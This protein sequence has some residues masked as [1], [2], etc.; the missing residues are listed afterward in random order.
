MLVMSLSP[1]LGLR[2]PPNDLPTFQRTSRLFCARVQLLPRKTHTF[3]SAEGPPDFSRHPPRM[4]LEGH[5][6]GGATIPLK[7]NA[8]GAWCR[9]TTCEFTCRATFP[10]KQQVLLCVT[11]PSSNNSSKHTGVSSHMRINLP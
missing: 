10:G 11:R 8:F 7:I 1:L 3:W 4:A 2:H 5:A 9:Q 6:A